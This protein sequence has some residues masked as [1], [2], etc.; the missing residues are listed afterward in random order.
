MRVVAAGAR[1]GS[2]DDGKERW[3]GTKHGKTYGRNKTQAGLLCSRPHR[4]LEVVE[5]VGALLH[6]LG[7]VLRAQ[8]SLRAELAE[9]PLHH[10]LHRPA[11]VPHQGAHELVF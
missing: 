11:C 8:L 5:R 1:A 3:H 9:A 7:Q 10:V 2:G 4:G 6:D